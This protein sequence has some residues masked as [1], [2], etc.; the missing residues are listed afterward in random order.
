[1][2]LPPE[3]RRVTVFLRSVTASHWWLLPPATPGYGLAGFTVIGERGA[4]RVEQGEVGV[5]HVGESGVRSLDAYFAPEVNGRLRGALQAEVDHFIEVARGAAEP[6]CAAED[7]TEA[8]RISLAMERSAQT[9]T[10][11]EL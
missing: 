9:G 1:M 8:P 7:G 10:A 2:R 6:A 3:Q 11:V 5:L 4:L